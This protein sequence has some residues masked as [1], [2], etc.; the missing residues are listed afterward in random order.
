M[1]PDLTVMG[2]N[3]ISKVVQRKLLRYMYTL[4]IVQGSNLNRIVHSHI[5]HITRWSVI[6]ICMS[7]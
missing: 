2:Y 6:F 1:T 5:N 4:N 7:V 3:N